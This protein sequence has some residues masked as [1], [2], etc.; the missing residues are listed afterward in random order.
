MRCIPIRRFAALLCLVPGMAGCA[1]RAHSAP[2]ASAPEQAPRPAVADFLA[3]VPMIVEVVPARLR[4]EHPL[5]LDLRSFVLA[6][7]SLTAEDLTPE[8][9]EDA[10]GLPFADV[11]AAEAVVRTSS[12]VYGTVDGGVH[13][14][15]D[16]ISGGGDRYSALI[17]YQH[18][19][20]NAVG[21]TE[22]YA[23]FH[24][25]RGRWTRVG[26]AILRTT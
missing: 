19:H 6:G 8:R 13:V 2:P 4:A 17:T 26:E 3:L 11:A 7:S 20:G 10:V 9:V 18:P 25:D 16:G 14:R 21:R 23:T 1:A 12:T 5:L 15:L 24:R 22:V